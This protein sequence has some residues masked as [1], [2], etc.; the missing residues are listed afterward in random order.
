MR[1]RTTN[2]HEKARKMLRNSWLFVLI[3]GS[4]FKRRGV[5]AHL[6]KFDTKQLIYRAS[7]ILVFSTGVFAQSAAE[8]KKLDEF[9]YTNCCDFGARIDWATITQREN[10]GSKIYIIFYQ[11]KKVAGRRWNHKLQNSED[12]LFNPV[13]GEFRGLVRGIMK[14]AEFLKADT[15]DLIIKNGGFRELLTVEVWIVPAGA[16]PP[17]LTPT[18]DGKDVRFTKGRPYFQHICDNI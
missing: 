17:A 9:S 11:G 8:T 10:P 14:R 18:I 4:L 13:R 3:R 1:I 5:L 7:L 15:K 6:I 12:A 2:T 16:E